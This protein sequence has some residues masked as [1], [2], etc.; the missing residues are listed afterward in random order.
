MPEHIEC[1]KVWQVLDQPVGI[2]RQVRQ[3]CLRK[4]ASEGGQMTTADLAGCAVHQRHGL[5]DVQQLALGH[6]Q[7]A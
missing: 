2:E 3:N 6:A 4:I 1:I 5:G 7:I